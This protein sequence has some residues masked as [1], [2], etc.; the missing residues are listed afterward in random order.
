M[1]FATMSIVLACRDGMFGT[2]DDICG[3]GSSKELV[4]S[5]S[6]KNWWRGIFDRR[7][8]E[9]DWVTAVDKQ[10]TISW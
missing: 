5:S 8:K 9:F 10:N 7:F 4:T 3:G 2:I 1:S 6:T